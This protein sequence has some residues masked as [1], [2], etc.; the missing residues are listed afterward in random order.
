MR[1]IVML[2]FAFIFLSLVVVGV[3]VYLRTQSGSCYWD[4]QI[5][6]QDELHKRAMRNLIIS[7]IKISHSE[8]MD[9][10]G[11][12]ILLVGKKITTN[13]VA[14]FVG[15]KKI[16][17]I[18]KHADYQ[19]RSADELMRVNPDFFNGDF[20][21]INFLSGA[22]YITTSEGVSTVD[23]ESA[24]KEIKKRRGDG[25]SLSVIE[26]FLGYGSHF[27][28]VN[29]FIKIDLGCCE[30]IYE[31]YPKNGK[32]QKWYA[33]E[34]VGLINKGG[35]PVRRLVVTSNCGEILRRSDDGYSWVL[36]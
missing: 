24:I 17:E 22:V 35:T 33:D 29:D 12:D 8:N 32:S 1:K 19:I 2:A 36:F 18:R 27:F 34:V 21:I 11:V 30:S 20:S 6:A 5:L 13:E 3:G 25:L 23:R 9:R 15:H 4:D 16:N 10:Q 28:L 7:K 26:R 14:D 31:K